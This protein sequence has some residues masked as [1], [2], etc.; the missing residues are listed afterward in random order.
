MEGVRAAADTETPAPGAQHPFP[1][2]VAGPVSTGLGLAAH[3]A[4]G[5]QAPAILILIAVA[6]L[7]GMAA[8]MAGRRR[9]PGWAVLVAAGVAQQLLHLAFASF[10]T[11]SG[12]ALPDHHGGAPVPETPNAGVPTAEASGAA[13]SLHLMLHFHVAA[14]LAAAAVTT[15]W[16]RVVSVMR[17]R[18]R[19]GGE[20][21]PGDADA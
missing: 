19:S 1:V 10:S 7:L 5:G 2:W 15:Q 9:F 16:T 20:R 17:R 12:F 18:R 11:A 4:A 13:H 14:A 3:L 21:A 6:A 8:A